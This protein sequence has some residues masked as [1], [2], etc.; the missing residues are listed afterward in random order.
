MKTKNRVMT[1]LVCAAFIFSLS[2]CTTKT[3]NVSEGEESDISTVTEEEK[4]DTTVTEDSSETY[5][6]EFSVDKTTADTQDT[7]TYS[8]TYKPSTP[9]SSESQKASR[10]SSVKT[11]D[12][13]KAMIRIRGCIGKTR[14]QRYISPRAAAY[15]IRECLS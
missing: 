15:G 8:T 7:D 11:P 6:A 9:V 4:S 5:T 2:G 13:Q 12:V 3:G 1:L 14:V 10:S